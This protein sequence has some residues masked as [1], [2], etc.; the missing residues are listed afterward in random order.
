MLIEQYG[1]ENT[2]RYDVFRKIVDSQH[3]M[4][5]EDRSSEA[6]KSTN[7]SSVHLR[8]EL[9]RRDINEMWRD[10][11][12]DNIGPWR[13]TIPVD[14][15]LFD[16]LTEAMISSGALDQDGVKAYFETYMPQFESLANLAGVNKA[17][18]AIAN[19]PKQQGRER[20]ARHMQ[21]MLNGWTDADEEEFHAPGDRF[22]EAN[23]DHS[24]YQVWEQR[25]TAT[26]SWLAEHPNGIEREL[27]D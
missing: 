23:P 17:I 18:D 20:V 6:T 13:A 26:R 10:M 5:I 2:E 14:L 8:F 21:A 25:L 16:P 11:I 27:A 19:H 7:H 1:F 9:A 22:M 4:I 3:A 24:A 15:L 12:N